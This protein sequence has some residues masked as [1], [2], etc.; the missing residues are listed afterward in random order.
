MGVNI[1]GALIPMR[2]RRAI[3]MPTREE[4]ERA[5]L[6]A[7]SADPLVWAMKS[8]DD[9]F[10]DSR[11]KDVETIKAEAEAEMRLGSTDAAEENVEEYGEDDGAYDEEEI[12]N[13]DDEILDDENDVDLLSNNKGMLDEI[14]AEGKTVAATDGGAVTMEVTPMRQD[15]TNVPLEEVKKA[16]KEEIK[17][18]EPKSKFKFSKNDEKKTEAKAG[19][20]KLMNLNFKQKKMMIGISA[21]SIIAVL[22][23]SFGVIATVKQSQAVEELTLQIAESNLA[24]EDETVDDEYIY[25]KDWGIKI[26][27]VSGLENVSYNTLMDDYAEVQ[28]WGSKKDASA[29]YVPSFAKQNKNATPLG[30]MVRVPRYERAAAGRLIWYDDYYNYYYQ[31]PSGVPTV[32]EDEM[33]WW[34]ESYLLVKEMLTNADNY[35]EI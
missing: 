27:I 33:S 11:E 7:A 20:K 26:Q 12:L 21:L 5:K 34:V 25:L 15:V 28:I 4:K 29:N 17:E 1:S 10:P 32:S 30:T 13:D 22:G 14:E 8:V 2:R 35:T 3:P 9:E 19:V 23:V 6:K 24:A 18:S 31:G 16:P